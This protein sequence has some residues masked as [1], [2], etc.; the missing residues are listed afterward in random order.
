L[1]DR[2]PGADSV[3]VAYPTDIGSGLGVVRAARG[4]PPVVGGVEG[5]SG[6]IANDPFRVADDAVAVG[7]VAYSGRACA[8]WIRIKRSVD[9]NAMSVVG[10]RVLD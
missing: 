2:G 5:G 4:A 3:V 10:N 8:L 7:E 6:V 1:R 9:L